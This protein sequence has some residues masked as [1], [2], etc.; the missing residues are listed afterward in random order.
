MVWGFGDWLENRFPG[1]GKHQM[2][3]ANLAL[4]W[5]YRRALGKKQG[6][7]CIKTGKNL[8][9]AGVIYPSKNGVFPLFCN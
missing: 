3:A 7:T 1:N 4:N 9:D 8:S 2:S 5:N 6:S